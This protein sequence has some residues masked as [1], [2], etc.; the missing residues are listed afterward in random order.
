MRKI[1]SSENSRITTVTRRWPCKSCGHASL[2][3]RSLNLLLALFYFRI[4]KIFLSS[5]KKKTI[6]R[7]KLTKVQAIKKTVDLSAE[8][9]QN[10][11]AHPK[12]HEGFRPM[13]D[14]R[15]ASQSG[16]GGILGLFWP[17]EARTTSNMQRSQACNQGNQLNTVCSHDRCWDFI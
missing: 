5:K 9:G 4:T 12:C 13:L 11:Q 2:P 16:A 7:V 8:K 1:Y 15:D 3:E 6:K 17:P 10:P 14:S